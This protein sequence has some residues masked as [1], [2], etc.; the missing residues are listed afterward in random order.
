ML[1]TRIYGIYKVKGSFEECLHLVTQIDG[2][3][4]TDRRISGFMFSPSGE[5]RC[6]FTKY[7]R[8]FV[9]EVGYAYIPNT[10]KLML[11]PVA[12]AEIGKCKN[13]DG[14]GFVD[15]YN[16]TRFGCKKCNGTGVAPAG[17]RSDQ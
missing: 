12:P 14:N 1:K 2:E 5:M 7:E 17:Q 13:C 16:G 3:F 15:D 11:V 6:G 4:D 8:S 9:E 10:H